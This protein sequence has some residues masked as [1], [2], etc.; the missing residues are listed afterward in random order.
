[1]RCHKI[2]MQGWEALCVG[3]LTFVGNL[4]YFTPLNVF[5]P[6][7]FGGGG[8]WGAVCIIHMT[9]ELKTHKNELLLCLFT[10]FNKAVNSVRFQLAS[11]LVES[12]STSRT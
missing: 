9:E 6:P 12:H 2:K 4:I 1:M 7:F 5:I 10:P 3:L 8:V 11:Q